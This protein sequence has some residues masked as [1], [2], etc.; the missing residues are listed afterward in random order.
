MKKTKREYWVTRLEEIKVGPRKKWTRIFKCKLKGWV[1]TK[2]RLAISWLK[3]ILVLTVGQS[4]GPV[5]RGGLPGLVPVIFEILAT[6]KIGS[7]LKS[8][9]SRVQVTPETFHQAWLSSINSNTLIMFY[10]QRSKKETGWQISDFP[11]CCLKV[12]LNFL[13]N[14]SW[15]GVASR[16]NVGYYD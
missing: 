9:E 14:F 8:C 12:L 15:F 3:I 5:E 16:T 7:E 1:N 13:M 6:S 2:Q 4:G 11:G 10:K